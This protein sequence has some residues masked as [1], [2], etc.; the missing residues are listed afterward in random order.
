MIASKRDMYGFC[1]GG[2]NKCA[3]KP[4][5]EEYCYCDV[6]CVSDEN[7]KCCKD[8]GSQF[9]N[10]NNNFYYLLSCCS[11]VKVAVMVMI[12]LMAFLR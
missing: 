2:P 3:A 6:G 11:Y 8:L 9:Y 1:M 12:R 5:G 7:R 10:K 4:D